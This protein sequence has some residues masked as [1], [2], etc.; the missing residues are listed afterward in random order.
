MPSIRE[1]MV[2]LPP[3]YG[4][5][6]DDLKRAILPESFEVLFSLSDKWMFGTLVEPYLPLYA[7][8]QFNYSASF[9]GSGGI[10]WADQPF[11]IPTYDEL[12][13]NEMG[14][15]FGP[16]SRQ[17]RRYDEGITDSSP[18]MCL[19]TRKTVTTLWLTARHFVG[20]DVPILRS[21]D[22]SFTTAE[23]QRWLDPTARPTNCNMIFDYEIVEGDCEC[24]VRIPSIDFFPI[25]FSIS[26]ICYIPF[27]PFSAL[28]R[29]PS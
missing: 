21:Q 14:S 2:K 27:P 11:V 23:L 1:I 8:L 18:T 17:A 16:F 19:R 3:L 22:L 15:P 9:I 4:L 28:F 25:H 29:F 10:A 20:Y 12:H 7:E 24:V 5:P 6:D 13:G 26:P